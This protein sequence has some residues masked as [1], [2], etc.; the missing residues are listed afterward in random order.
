MGTIWWLIIALLLV[1]S[2]LMRNNL[3]FLI[4]LFLLLIAGVSQLWTRYCL[5]GVGYRRWFGNARLFFGEETELSLEFV[6]AKPLPLA[7]LRVEDDIT[8]SFELTGA[9]TE[10]SHL[11]GLIR[12]VNLM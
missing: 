3:L 10:G 6:N 9:K 7:W 11:V 8:A 4:G 2:A 5:A 12:L 1:S